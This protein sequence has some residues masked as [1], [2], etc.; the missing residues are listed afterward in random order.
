MR[1]LP[2]RLPF[3][4]P[5]LHFLLF[6]TT[7]FFGDKIASGGNPLFCVDLPVSLPLVASDNTPRVIVVGIVATMWWY[8]IGKIASVAW[9]GKIS[10]MISVAGSLLLFLLGGVGS[11]AM[12]SEFR[13][14]S[15][16]PNFGNK[17]FFVYTL[18]VVLL[19]GEFACAGY[20]TASRFRSRR[21]AN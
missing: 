21:W 13:L 16:E 2:E 3:V 19:F 8:L 17:D 6:F 11:F 18:A 10:R 20:A 15:Q 9:Q 14:I 5:A 12:I 4:L 7:E 1:H